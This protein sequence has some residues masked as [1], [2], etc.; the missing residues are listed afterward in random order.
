MTYEKSQ[1][2][3]DL[4]ERVRIP[5]HK[6]SPG[7]QVF[8]RK[9][10]NTTAEEKDKLEPISTGPYKVTEVDENNCV[11]L[12]DNIIF[13]MVYLERVFISPKGMVD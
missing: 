7:S 3:Q 9:D 12:R 11:I 10:Y 1:Y 4:D 13:E 8:L 2:K 5:R 6:V